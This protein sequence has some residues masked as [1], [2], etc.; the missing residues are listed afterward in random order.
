LAVSLSSSNRMRNAVCAPA[1]SKTSIPCSALLG[2]S[3][4]LHANRPP[5][6]L[7]RP[8]R[9]AP[10]TSPGQGEK[11]DEAEVPFVTEPTVGLGQYPKRA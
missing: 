5:A 2:L 7:P 10:C 11:V 4:I 1:T 6:P 9:L 3:Q 8:V